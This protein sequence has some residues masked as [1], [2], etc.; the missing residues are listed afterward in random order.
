MIL[1]VD[2]GEEGRIDRA[3]LLINAPLPDRNIRYLAE[4][5]RPV[6]VHLEP[7]VISGLIFVGHGCVTREHPHEEHTNLVSMPLAVQVVSHGTEDRE[8]WGRNLPYYWTKNCVCRIHL[9]LLVQRN[10]CLP[11]GNL[12]FD[13]SP[14]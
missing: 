11:Y 8:V 14:Y 2:A 6:D 7:R 4:E 12:L 3:S 10:R 13:S 5:L 1:T 9:F